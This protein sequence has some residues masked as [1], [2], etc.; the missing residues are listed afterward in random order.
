MPNYQFILTPVDKFFF[1]GEKHNADGYSINYFVESNPYPQQTTILGLVRYYLLKQ[2][3]LI[4]NNDRIKSEGKKLIG[5]KS[6]DFD[7]ANQQF[8]NIKSV[9]PLY[10]INSSETWFP[11]PFDSQHKLSKLD[12]Y[13]K[14]ITDHGKNYTAKDGG[15][16]LRLTNGKGNYQLLS[17]I[18][19]PVPQTGNEKGEKGSTKEDAYYKQVF[20]QIKPGWSFA[21]DVELSQDITKEELFVN[22]GG[23][24]SLFSLKI[25]PGRKPFDF[26]YSFPENKKRENVFGF[27]C[28]SDCFANPDISGNTCFGIIQGMSFRNFQSSIETKNYAAYNSSDPNGM[29][30]GKRFNLLAR[31]SALYF[32]TIDL[33]DKA[34]ETINNSNGSAIGFNQIITIN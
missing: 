1:G 17:E 13:Y 6:F 28:L 7:V 4:G 3:G 33:R 25:I 9:S 10:F 31:G 2:N 5:E 20:M 8:G 22:F 16:E 24:K 18:I 30:R 15:F 34:A 12:G 23:E 26:R 19:Y 14:F 29:I 21:F 27:Y 11:A 32:E